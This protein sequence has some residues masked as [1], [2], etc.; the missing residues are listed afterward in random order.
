MVA[1]GS[2]LESVSVFGITF[3]GLLISQKA[4]VLLAWVILA[5]RRC[6]KVFGNNCGMG[7]GLPTN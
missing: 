4:V 5:M 3:L 2:I 7:G 1:M 6:L